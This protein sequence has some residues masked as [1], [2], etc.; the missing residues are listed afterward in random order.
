MSTTGRLVAALALVA[1]VAL[2]APS[3]HAQQTDPNSPELLA[4]RLTPEGIAKLRQVM[5]AMD[6]DKVPA[7]DAVRSDIA[8]VTGLGRNV[9]KR[10]P[11]SD[12]K[13]RETVSL[14][15]SAHVPLRDAIK[16]AGWTSR[17]YVMSWMTLMTAYP[18]VTAKRNGRT[19]ETGAAP[20]NVAFVERHWTDVDKLMTEVGDR[21]VR[22]RPPEASGTPGMPPGMPPQ[23]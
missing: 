22:S 8:V 10:Q 23:K 13:V 9:P 17:D 6:E 7:P 1:L 2:L 3:A 14:L 20:D 11:F 15:E 21:I 19:L 16:R 18:V 4:Y 5:V 12:A